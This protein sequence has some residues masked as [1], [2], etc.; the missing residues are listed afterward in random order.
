MSRLDKINEL[1]QKLQVEP[2]TA[3]QRLLNLFDPNSFV[4]IGS[5]SKDAGVVAGY[6]SI[7]GKL[8]YA[9][10]QEGIVNTDHARKIDN[11]YALA[12]K[13]GCPVVA[14]MD[15]KGMEI[16]GGLD[17][18]E[19]YGIIFM[20]QTAASGVVP[21]ISIILGDSLG[22]SSYLS[23]FSDF[24]IMSEQGARMFMSSPSVFDGIDGKSTTYEEIGNS[25]SMSKNGIVHFNCH[26][27][28]ESIQKAR[29]L[30]GFLP[31]N[32]LDEIIMPQGQDDLNRVDEMLNSIIPE[33]DVTP[34]D[35]KQI[36]SSVAD[37]N[38]FLEISE[39]YATNIIAGFVRFDGMTVGILA[40]NGK[41][42]VDVAKKAGAFVNICDAFNIPIVTFTD[43]T[44]YETTNTKQDKE[45]IKYG[46]KLMY[47]FA[48]ATVP[49]IN[50]ILRNAIGNAY[51]LMNSK[52]IG[53]DI[54]YAWPSACISLLSKE[55]ATNIMNISNETYDEIA[56]PYEVAS[57]GYIDGIIIPANTRKRILISLEMLMTKRENII[58][59]KHSSVEF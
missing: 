20:N 4:E 8:V 59:K 31:S 12:L 58:A 15:S 47:A 26:D 17:T 24:V 37:N 19:A 48:N 51:M 42:N 7:D 46:G 11:V 21:Q 39:L 6:G 41:F 50:I 54:V 23:V 14:I 44:G 22:V 1:V 28:S 55:A 2:S 29:D 53:A 35:V 49:K 25:K 27:E 33:D 30:I 38:H 18:L 16:E 5:Y 52:H 10:A 3:S 45:L 57:K 36:I 32:N 43:I 34:I 9:F 40:N 56:S 13:M